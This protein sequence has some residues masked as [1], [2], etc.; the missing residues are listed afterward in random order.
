MLDIDL[1]YPYPNKL[2]LTLL[3]KS[4]LRHY[5]KYTIEKYLLRMIIIKIYNSKHMI[6][7]SITLSK[8]SYIKGLLCI[9]LCRHNGLGLI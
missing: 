1:L 3:S 8:R 5:V 4:Y 6:D 7:I 2:A 9:M